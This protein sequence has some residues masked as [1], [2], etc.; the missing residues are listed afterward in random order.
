M[1]I[2]HILPSLKGG[3]IQNFIFSLAPRLVQMGN[4][5]IIMVTDE[6]NIEYSIRQKKILEQCHIRVINLNRKIGSRISIIRTIRLAR[7]HLKALKANVINSHGIICHTIATI[8]SIGLK[9]KHCCTIHSAPETW[10]KFSKIINYN[11]PLI[12]CS[13]S[14][15]ILR[16][17][18]GNPMIAINN[19]IDFEKVSTSEII[20]LRDEL[21]IPKEDK[22]VVLVGST[23]PPKNYPFLIK[24][25][26]KIKNNH[27]HFCICG[28]S[29]KVGRNSSNNKNYIS[30]EQ[31]EKYDNI[32]LL[33][34][35]DDVMAILNGSDVYMSCSIR[36]GLPISALEAFS[37]GIPCVLSPIMQHTT[38]AEG[39]AEC[40][41][42]KAFTEESFI[43]SI[44]QA[45]NCTLDH[46]T[47]Y[48]QRKLAL[49]K[50]SIERCAKEYNDFYYQLLKK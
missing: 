18:K 34:L 14:A 39:I 36:E 1:R 10:S 49:Q 40:Y 22:I 37:S 11:K 20:N 27:I 23:R 4:E 16:G 28:G 35:R 5:V 25:V 30:T 26:E 13:D 41:I 32:H 7:K 29:Y 19:G 24:V 3:G 17:Q 46:N 47:I 45:L 31:F 48:E 8:S 2:V 33:G 9:S 21:N 6:D 43:D 50:F 12:Y 44:Y 42:P 38:I 15:Y